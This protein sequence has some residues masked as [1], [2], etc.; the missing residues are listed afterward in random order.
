LADWRE[1]ARFR[2]GRKF[3]MDVGRGKIVSFEEREIKG[4]LKNREK[5]AG[6]GFVPRLTSNETPRFGDCRDE[7]WDLEMGALEGAMAL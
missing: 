5:H 6:R 1:R 3:R 7:P 2:A 4:G